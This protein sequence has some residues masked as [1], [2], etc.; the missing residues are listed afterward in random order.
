LGTLNQSLLGNNIISVKEHNLQVILLSLLYEENLSRIE[1]AQRTNL[2]N[3]TITNLIAQLLEEGL[4]S[5][6]NCDD[7]DPGVNRPVGR[8]RTAIC[9]EPSARFVIGVH[10]GVGT[11]R[12]AL[13]NLR[14]ELQLTVA[15]SFN[16]Q[17]DAFGVIDQ[18]I[19]CIKKVIAESQV[20]TDLILG[21]GMGLSGLVNFQS[22]VN[23][24]APN[25]NWRNVHVK[26]IVSEKLDL[27]VVVDNN[28]RC[29]ALGET[30]F[31]VGRGLDSLVFVYG[32]IG[33]GAGF[34]S[35]G[36][37]F[38]G[39]A[40]G[41]GEIG[42]TTMLLSGGE[43]CRCG[44]SGCL[45]T[46]VSE[47]AIAREAQALNQNFPDGILAHRIQS[48]PDQHKMDVVFEA[49]R[50]GDERVREMLA[51][52]AFYLGVALANMVNL[53]NPELILLG[54]IFAQDEEYFID[55][56]IRTVREMTFGNLGKQVRIEATSFGWKAGLVGAAALALTQ[57]FYF[58][59]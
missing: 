28:V 35:K 19:C 46:L 6:S 25:L 56:V 41:A 53:Y 14:D 2:S 40:M 21:V 29:M 59:D 49:A 50:L 42:H 11:F 58:R 16:I 20:N 4:V 30:Y 10:V 34:I 33:V 1:L 36:Q 31:G 15:E 8:P 43:P 54:G 27:P 52:R 3:T 5:E 57:F 9:L 48:Q 17:D 26:E 12:V 18:I 51:D 45:E 23:V 13:A 39:S 7:L 38:R 32:R 47:T 44:K 55:P 37:V 24:M 22:G